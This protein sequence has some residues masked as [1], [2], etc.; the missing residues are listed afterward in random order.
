M[1]GKRLNV[2]LSAQDD[3]SGVFNSAFL[4]A[5]AGVLGLKGRIDDLDAAQEN[6]AAGAGKIKERYGELTSASSELARSVGEIDGAFGKLGASA[7]DAGGPL[8]SILES[9]RSQLGA[10]KEAYLREAEEFYGEVYGRRIVFA[11][12]EFTALKGFNELYVDSV[13]ARERVESTAYKAM[14]DQLLRLVEIHSFSAKEFG[15]AVAQQVKVELTG[16]A[17]RAVIWAI[18]ETAMGFRDLAMGSPTAAL[19]FTSAAQF[20]AVAGAALA[21]AAGVQEVVGGQASTS[22]SGGSSV[23]RVKSLPSGGADASVAPTQ[24]ITIHVYNP[25]SEQNW[26]KIVDDNIIP[27]LKDAGDRNVAV[28]VKT[29]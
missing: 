3:F 19:H 1:A 15:K 17:A 12:M 13:K 14:G 27:A 20:G 2:I 21:A 7:K 29:S 4:A 10:A 9:D 6:A 26:Q 23:A 5:E 24:N 8:Q 28:T 25:L 22:S 18:F 11:E 16:L